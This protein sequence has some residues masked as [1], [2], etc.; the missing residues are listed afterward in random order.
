[1]LYIDKIKLLMIMIFF[2]LL[3]FY[4]HNLIKILIFINDIFKYFLSQKINVVK[5]NKLLYSIN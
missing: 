2:D 3:Y 5:L 1:M 4:I